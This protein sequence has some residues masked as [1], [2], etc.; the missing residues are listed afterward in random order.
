MAREAMQRLLA[1]VMGTAPAPEALR[2]PKDEAGS[3]KVVPFRKSS[4]KARGS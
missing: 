2:G 1:D 3:K 4:K